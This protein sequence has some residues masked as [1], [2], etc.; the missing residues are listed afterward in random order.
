[1]KK[2]LSVLLSVLMIVG[3]LSVGFSAFAEEAEPTEAE[4]LINKI[5]E[6]IVAATTEDYDEN[7]NITR[8][9]A[10]YWYGRNLQTMEVEVDG[11]AKNYLGTL[12]KSQYPEYSAFTVEVPLDEEGHTRSYPNFSA[13][14]TYILSGKLENAGPIDSTN[15]ETLFDSFNEAT[16]LDKQVRKNTDAYETLDPEDVLREFEID[17]ETVEAIDE[18]DENTLVFKD[19]D[20]VAGDKVADSVIPVIASV[21]PDL[22]G[23]SKGIIKKAGDAGLKMENY[24]LKYTNI[25][26]AAQ[27]DEDKLMGLSLTY[28]II[29]SA[30]MSFNGQ[31]MTLTAASENNKVEYYNF[32]YFDE[33]NE[34]DYAELVRMINEGTA[35]AVDS[36]TGYEYTRSADTDNNQAI[37]LDLTGETYEALSGLSDSAQQGIFGVI[38]QVTVAID[39]MAGTSI[40]KYEWVCDGENCPVCANNP[41]DT[42]GK[43]I[44]CKEGDHSS[45]VTKKWVCQGNNCPV[46]NQHQDDNGNIIECENNDWM[47]AYVR[48][49][50][51][52]FDDEQVAEE[53]ASMKERCTCGEEDAPACTCSHRIAPH[54][55]SVEVM[56]K[57]Y[58]INMLLDKGIT[59]ITGKLNDTQK[60]SL[61]KLMELG[62]YHATVPESKNPDEYI[63]SKYALKA[64]SL[65]V[66]DLDPDANDPYEVIF[67]DGV[68]SFYIPYQENPGYDSA[69]A[70]LTDDFV[71]GDDFKAA[72]AEALTQRIDGDVI[73]NLSSG[74]VYSGNESAEPDDPQPDVTNAYT[75]IKVQVAFKGATEDNIYGNGDIEKLI[76]NYTCYYEYGLAAAN[77]LKIAEATYSSHMDSTYLVGDKPEYEKG[78]TD[79]SGRVSIIDAKLVLK[80]IVGTE[81][82]NEIQQEIADMDNDGVLTTKDAKMILQKIAEEA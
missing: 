58:D 46:C 51:F 16:S 64:T 26:L 49:T 25:K 76:I 43:L 41:V 30:D 18:E 24:V 32:E 50:Y 59:A 29:A 2:L 79:L 36:R 1:M 39:N 12:L 44:P 13:I 77:F 69:L 33:G 42:D 21:Y 56:G 31:A 35:K 5:N 47:E 57:T 53:V 20:I 60:D 40:T 68:I 80:Y 67:E 37:K 27:F 73:N 48:E 62:T 34:F 66:N 63:E 38:D 81:E 71:T 3:C 11:D 55:L 45:E 23:V 70:H 28:D 54:K 82:L 14:G 15:A 52:W 7:G 72:T 19:I 61:T 75:P 10:G 22:T 65:T 8:H 74:I 6:A 78:D 9:T 17:P 4:A